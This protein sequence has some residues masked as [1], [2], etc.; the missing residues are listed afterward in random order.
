MKTANVRTKARWEVFGWKPPL[1]PILLNSWVKSTLVFGFYS[2]T[3]L[4]IYSRL[5]DRIYEHLRFLFIFDT[6]ASA[7]VKCDVDS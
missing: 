3:S 6:L 7:G 4:N 1:V 5:F 2:S